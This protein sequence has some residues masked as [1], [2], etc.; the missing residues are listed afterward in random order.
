MQEGQL[1]GAAT[2]L[3]QG[4]STEGRDK[5]GELPCA[6]CQGEMFTGSSSSMCTDSVKRP[7]FM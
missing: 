2:A 1:Q 4:M 7:V 5:L 3:G 6:K